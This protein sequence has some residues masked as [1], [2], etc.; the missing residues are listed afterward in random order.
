M[1]HFNELKRRA[2]ALLAQVE[3]GK[4]YTVGYVSQRLCKAAADNPQDVVIRAVAGV[5]ET[6]DRQHPGKLISQGELD[7]IYNQLIGLD[8]SGT[9]FRDVLGDLLLSHKPASVSPDP[10]YAEARRDPLQEAISETEPQLAKELGAMFDFADSHYDPQRALEARE[11]VGLGLHAMGLRNAR[12]RIAGGNSRHLVFAADLDTNRGAVRVYIPVESSGDRQPSVF[13]AGDRFA[14][15]TI[16]N[17]KAHLEQV[18]QRNERL[19]EVSSI[20]KSLD[21]ITMQT[22]RQAT[23][24]EVGK[25]ASMLPTDNGS[26]ALS[27]PGLF[28]SLPEG[29]GIGEVEI[30]KAPVPESLKVLTSEIE[31]S[32]LEASVGYPQMA[33]RLAKRMLLAELTSM[34]FK[35]SQVRV[36]APTGDG[37]ICE[38]VLNTPC[39]KVAIDVPIEMKDNQPLMPS[40]F[41]QGD[42]VED[43]NES[44]LKAM[45]ARDPDTV[46]IA[47]RRDSDLL[48]MGYHD[49]KD[50]LVRQAADGNFK[51]CDEIME[52]IAEKFDGETYR[53][54]LS[55]YQKILT[56]L[57][58]AKKQAESRCG[59]ILRSSNSIFPMCGHFMVPLHKVVQDEHGACHLAST[60]H[61]RKNQQE[62][63]AFFSTAKILVGDK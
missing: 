24:E 25:I 35:G 51:A 29:K 59:R 63:G 33:V 46:N 44:N 49:L 62:E 52:A 58:S 6:M 18:S 50:A 15:L 36:A 45:L 37:F 47:V 30:P 16:P 1:S 43:F 26:S 54:A 55:D 56:D 12:V 31:E 27:A 20:L 41:A 32:V 4:T 53:N 57:G 60:Y 5:L 34:G 14:E 48:G 13:V 22:K 11:K 21:I 61:A 3:S 40:V 7:G 8:T 28:A 17:L 38:A 2:E 39:G 42:K 9:R 23:V 10:K 19:P